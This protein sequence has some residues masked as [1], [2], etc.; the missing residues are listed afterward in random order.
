[1]NSP[2]FSFVRPHNTS[3]EQDIDV[4]L[5]ETALVTL[6]VRAE[7]RHGKLMMGLTRE[8]FH[9]YE[10][11]VMLRIHGRKIGGMRNNLSLPSIT[12]SGVKKPSP[13]RSLVRLLKVQI[14]PNFS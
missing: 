8:Q 14:A 7:D 10:D 12:I 3:V 4:I 1:M 5:V 2:L 13:R 9:V 6:A 11:G